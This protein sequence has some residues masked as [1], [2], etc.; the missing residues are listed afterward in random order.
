MILCSSNQEG[1]D[2]VIPICHT[3]QPLSR[4]SVTAILVRVKN[5][6]KYQFKF[7]KPLSDGMDPIKLGLFP[8]K[9]V[10]KPVIRIVFALAAVDTGIY[11]PKA[12][13]REN[14]QCDKFTAFDVWCAGLAN[15]T[16][17]HI[18]ADLASYRLV[19]ERLLRPHASDAFE[20]QGAQKGHDEANRLRGSLRRRM[21]PLTIDDDAHHAIHLRKSAA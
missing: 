2:I 13:Q 21:A 18:G 7:H 12:R 3:Q 16:F 1:I 10:P 5:E 4:D 15:K 8:A 14:H 20:L 17:K 9:V 11:F 6:E 19:L